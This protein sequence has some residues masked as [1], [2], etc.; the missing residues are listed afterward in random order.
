MKSEFVFTQGASPIMKTIYTKV[1][2]TFCQLAC[3]THIS[4]FGLSVGSSKRVFEDC[5]NLE[6]TLGMICWVLFSVLC[7]KVNLFLRK[8]RPLYPLALAKR[9]AN[10]LIVYNYHQYFS[11]YA[12]PRFCV[13]NIYLLLIFSEIQ[14][15]FFF[16]FVRLTRWPFGPLAPWPAGPVISKFTMCEFFTPTRWPTDPLVLGFQY[17]SIISLRIFQVL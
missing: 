7:R 14:I 12:S 5:S 2:D 6:R 10:V 9:Y 17:V 15:Q 16:N 11:I 1:V 8:A 13:F 3:V 4:V